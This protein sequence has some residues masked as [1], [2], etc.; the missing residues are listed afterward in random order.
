MAMNC[1]EYPTAD[2]YTT[3][4]KYQT[5]IHLDDHHKPNVPLLPIVHVVHSEMR[6]NY[7]INK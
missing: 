4:L 2:K 1:Q 5:T 6:M 7:F 3:V